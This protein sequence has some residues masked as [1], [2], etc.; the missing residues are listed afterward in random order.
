[1]KTTKNEQTVEAL[2]AK[3]Q[4][5]NIVLASTIIAFAMLVTGF[6]LGYFVSINVVTSSQSQA[7]SFL[8]K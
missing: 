1:M 8:K 3:A 4:K 5:K 7:V 2:L 6:I